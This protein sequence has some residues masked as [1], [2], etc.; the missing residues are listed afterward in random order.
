MDASTIFASSMDIEMCDVSMRLI[1]LVIFLKLS[2][3]I[4]KRKKPF[5]SF[6]EKLKKIRISVYYNILLTELANTSNYLNCILIKIAHLTLFFV[7]LTAILLSLRLKITSF[8][9]LNN[10]KYPEVIY[11]I[12]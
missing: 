6:T 10:S 2:N 4:P 3:K 8:Y 5:F 11:Q 9:K 12:A 1:S 7:N